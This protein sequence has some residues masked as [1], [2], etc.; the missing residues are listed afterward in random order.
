VL[1]EK[2]PVPNGQHFSPIERNK[3]LNLLQH[4]YMIFIGFLN[5]L[6]IAYFHGTVYKYP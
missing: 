3:N 1:R 6:K 4:N 2:A 5:A